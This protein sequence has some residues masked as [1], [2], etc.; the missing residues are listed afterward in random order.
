MRMPTVVVPA[1]STLVSAA[2]VASSHSAISRGEPSTSTWPGPE[3][4]GGVFRPDGHL[5][6]AAQAGFEIHGTP[7]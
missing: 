1:G 3:G 4:A 6:V 5:C 2:M 7:R